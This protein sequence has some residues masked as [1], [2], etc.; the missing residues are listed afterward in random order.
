MTDGD[1]FSN[2]SLKPLKG[3][4]LI[5]LCC[6]LEHTASYACCE[7]TAD[8]IVNSKCAEMLNNWGDLSKSNQQKMQT[9]TQKQSWP[10]I[11]K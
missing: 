2:D 9:D 6:D 7:K 8:C 3:N 11:R 4:S 10:Y 5:R 1:L